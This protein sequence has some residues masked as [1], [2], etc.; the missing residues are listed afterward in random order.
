MQDFSSIGVFSALDLF[1]SRN[2]ELILGTV[3]CL[4]HYDQIVKRCNH[5]LTSEQ[6]P[7]DSPCQ[8]LV[9]G[10]VGSHQ[11]IDDTT[12]NVWFPQCESQH[13]FF[14]VP[15]L[16][17][18]CV[19]EGIDGYGDNWLQAE[20]FGNL[21]EAIKIRII[22]R[23]DEINIDR[24]PQKTMQLDGQSANEYIVDLG[25]GKRLKEFDYL[26]DSKP[27]AGRRFLFIAFLLVNT[28]RTGKSRRW[29]DGDKRS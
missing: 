19:L 5:D 27:E 16:N 2:I 14:A 23:Q 15:L 3:G 11:Y 20:L 7:S 6:R 22:H 1:Q 18:L 26:H 13:A 28:C 21:D 12:A 25:V 10:Y 24:R 29:R 4:L 9:E 8:Q 17:L